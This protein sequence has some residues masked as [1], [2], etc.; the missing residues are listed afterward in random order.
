MENLQKERLGKIMMEIVWWLV[1]A[2]AVFFIV[3][4]FWAN[5][6]QYGYIYR[7]M[8]YAVVFITFARYVFLLRYTFLAHFQKMKIFLIFLS[9]PLVFYMVQ[10]F[11]EFR[12]FLERQNSGLEEAQIYF[13]EDVGF[14]ERY[15]ILAYL[16]RVYT[17]FAIAAIITVVITPFR[18]LKSY[19]RVYNNTG[20]V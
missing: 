19:W 16:S 3:Q 13:K 15:E 6:K 18:L 11:F 12:D 14:Q 20:T 9:L 7:I 2:I 17:F 8:F 4:P 5:F 1:T 10:E